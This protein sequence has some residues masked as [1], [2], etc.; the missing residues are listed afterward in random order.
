MIHKIN[1]FESKRT[2]AEWYH[3]NNKYK[4]YD[5]NI[6]QDAIFKDFKTDTITKKDID[7][8][9]KKY[10]IPRH[11][12]SKI[13]PEEYDKAVFFDKHSMIMDKNL[14]DTKIEYLEKLYH[15]EDCRLTNIDKKSQGN[16]AQSTILIGFI[17]FISKLQVNSGEPFS[18]VVSI[19]ATLTVLGFVAAIICSFLALKPTG[20]MR[21]NPFII[22]D[23]IKENVHKQKLDY[24][25]TLYR[26]I[27]VNKIVN[28]KKA[29]ISKKSFS[30]FIVTLIIFSLSVAFIQVSNIL[31]S[32]K[33]NDSITL[34][35]EIIDLKYT[36]I[37]FG[38]SI[39][40]D[41]NYQNIELASNLTIIEAWKEFENRTHRILVKLNIDNDKYY[42]VDA[43][44]KDPLFDDLTINLVLDLESIYIQALKS[45]SMKVSDKN[46]FIY[47][48]YCDQLFAHIEAFIINSTVKQNIT[49]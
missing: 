36:G 1:R 46:I 7:N 10:K 6:L 34:A 22:L 9:I 28:E 24:L 26:C 4:K 23:N 29:Q 48:I 19:L 33:V 31:E 35:E 42:F 39:P 25:E 11:K 41:H 2:F 8:V 47:A 38:F 37:D 16:I 12:I 5:F 32:R 21:V 14:L 17:A 20:Y 45:Q 13:N 15:R 49:P 27:S 30:I 40:S 43:I 3:L 18:F 44:K